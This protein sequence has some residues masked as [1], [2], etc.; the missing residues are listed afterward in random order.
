VEVCP[1]LVHPRPKVT[2]LIQKKPNGK[3]NMLARTFT[4]AAFAITLAAAAHAQPPGYRGPANAAIHWN[5]VALDAFAPSEGTNPMA[6]SR[7]LAIFHA[8]IHDALNAIDQRFESYTP[9]LLA[10][11]NASPDATV[12]SAAREVLVTLL[13][14]QTSLVNVEYT[15]FLKTIPDGAAKTAGIATG[16]ASARATLATLMGSGPAACNGWFASV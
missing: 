9:G 12:A 8:A 3:F 5:N 13:P 15:R 11:P 16:M 7:T 1:D 4:V 6:Q 14:D 10:S 2:Q